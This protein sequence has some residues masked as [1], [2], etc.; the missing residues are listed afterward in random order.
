MKEKVFE[1]IAA[2]PG[3]V[4]G[5]I[6]LF[7]LEETSVVPHQIPEKEVG[8][9][10]ARFEDALIETRKELIRIRQ[11]LADRAGREVT[12]LF[13]AH[14]LVVEDRTL[15][16]EVVKGI[17]AKKVNAGYVFQE[18]MGEY[19]RAF[20]QVKDDYIKER[21]SDIRDVAR[22]VLHNLTGRKRAD[23][24]SLAEEVVV[25]AHDLSPSDTA[26]MH[27]ENVIGFATDIGGKTSH[28]A[29]M[30]RSLEIPA[31]VGLGDISI[32]ARSGDPVVVDGTDG[33][34]I[35]FPSRSTLAR[36]K[37]EQSD[38]ARFDARLKELKDVPAETRDGFRITLA[39][40]IEMPEDLPSVIAHGGQGV[41][42]YRTEYFYLNRADVPD[43]EEQFQAY[44]TVAAKMKPASVII[45]TL[46]LGGD[47][48][49]SALEI[50]REI[51]PFMGWRAI[52]FCLERQDI[53]KTQLRAILR[54]SC[55]KNVKVMFPMISGYAELKRVL[56]IWEDTK[57]GLKRQGIPFFPE[58]EVGIMI[59][60]PA[61]VVVAEVLARQVDFFSIGTND[62]I[63][64]TLAVDRVNEKIAYLYDPLN[65]AVLHLIHQT[66][67][68]GHRNNIW[69]G[70]CGEM[71]GDILSVPILLG[72]GLDEFSVSP[73]MIPE[74]K[75]IITSLRLAEARKLAQTVLQ[76]DSADQIR[77]EV[78]KILGRAVPMFFQREEHKR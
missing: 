29:I 76:Y 18:V 7:D 44:N 1:G 14:L 25:I 23:L 65:P 33:R 47:K 34:V 36:V 28:T 4:V 41:G 46:D 51:N 42:L 49:N 24:A 30:A 59:E 69:V 61:A 16:A 8:A 37:R 32:S 70:M 17:E 72:L 31:V 9:E 67:T 38:L 64:Y 73:A 40:N 57:N 66:I 52:R 39:A 21:L 45:R 15:I 71:A 6:Y 22:R 13:E 55:Q 77:D 10:I 68:I 63:Q 53:F 11:D 60:I 26:L 75:K 50:P 35:L 3:F 2:S 43:E 19:T 5:K 27:K 20:L 78:K 74:V 54:A 58:M 12:D 56:E 62:L 48:F